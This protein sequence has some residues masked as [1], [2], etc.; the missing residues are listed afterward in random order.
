MRYLLLPLL[1]GGLCTACGDG[2]ETREET[3]DFGYR[4]VYTVDPETDARHGMFRNYDAEGHLLEQAEYRDNV[5]H[6]QRVL[7][8]PQGDTLVVE[9][10]AGGAFEG[11]Y[12]AYYEDGNRL[13]QRGQYVSNNMAG[14]WTRFYSDGTKSEVVTFANNAENGPFR[15]W[16][17]NG[18]L[19]AVGSYRGGD[20][21]DG[22][23]R[24]FT[25]AGELQRVLE[26]DQGIC[27]TVWRLGDEGE[28]PASVYPAG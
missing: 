18:K 9:H 20:R 24:L 17:E 12:R 19:K 22:Q 23:L 27:Q 3:D 28:P 7:F 4:S 26:C 21:E 25:E 10:Y 14:Q 13:R 16:Y 6:G 15:E 8:S 5:L 1:L 2:L 11:P